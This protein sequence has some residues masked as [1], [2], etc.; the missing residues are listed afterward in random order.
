M[1]TTPRK[2]FS[3][4]DDDA[5][6]RP[7]HP[8]L[9]R[10]KTFITY[11]EVYG[12]SISYDEIVTL[13]QSLPTEYW[14]RTASMCRIFLEHYEGQDEFQGILFRYLCPQSLLEINI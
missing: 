7:W 14:L 11:E 2:E 5:Q 6:H 1:S 10:T 9:S 4:T 13:I 3:S 8:F 12:K